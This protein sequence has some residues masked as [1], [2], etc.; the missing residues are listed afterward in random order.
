MNRIPTR[1]R[2]R[3]DRGE[4]IVSLLIGV[5]I[6]MLVL[7]FFIQFWISAQRGGASMD[8]QA[9]AES[10]ALAALNRIGRDITDSSTILYADHDQI[11]VEKRTDDDTTRI[12]YVRTPESELVSQTLD[13]VTG[14][15]VHAP[16]TWAG[17]DETVLAS[18]MR[19]GSSDQV[20]F[21]VDRTGHTIDDDDIPLTGE[22]TRAISRVDM[23]F[24]G[25]AGKG[26]IELVS[27][28]AV[29]ARV[30]SGDPIALP[31]ACPTPVINTDPAE[32]YPTLEWT[33]VG[34][35]RE[36]IVTRIHRNTSTTVATIATVDGKR[37]YTFTDDT[38]PQ[39][40][41]AVTNYQVAAAG[42]GGVS[43]G[44]AFI[45]WVPQLDAPNVDGA[46]LPRVLEGQAWPVSA[47]SPAYDLDWEPVDGATTYDVYSR[48]VDRTTGQPM[49]DGTY[50]RDLTV[51]DTDAT[52]D[53]GYGVQR[54]FQVIAKNDYPQATSKPS[55]G[56]DL[57]THP[58]PTAPVADADTYSVN[59]VT[60]VNDGTADKYLISRRDADNPTS[61]FAPLA[62]AGGGD[63]AYTDALTANPADL[64]DQ[65][66][67][68]T[69]YEYRIEP[70]NNGPRGGNTSEAYT[71]K[72]SVA[73]EALQF[74]QDPAYVA[75][76]TGQSV[77]AAGTT[78][79]DYT[80][81]GR[82]VVSWPT[83]RHASSYKINRLWDDNISALNTTR[84]ASGTTLND[85][86]VARGS[87]YVYNP[88]AQNSTGTSPNAAA[89]RS[90][91]GMKEAY[92][93][94]AAPAVTLVEGADLDTKNSRIGWAGYAPDEANRAAGFAFC[95][96]V[97]CSQ[98]VFR[99]GA[100]VAT[101]APTQTMLWQN[102]AWGETASYQVETCNPGG[103]SE[104]GQ[105]TVNTYP[106]PFSFAPNS[107]VAVSQ[108]RWQ[109]YYHGANG[110]SNEPGSIEVD[111][112]TSVG[113]VHY[114]WSRTAQD[115]DP[116]RWG[117]SVGWTGTTGT[118][119]GALGYTPGYMYRYDV[120]AVA[121]NGLSRSIR[122]DGNNI[123]HPGDGETWV[124]TQPAPPSFAQTGAFCSPGTIA[125]GWK[126]GWQVLLEPSSAGTT[127]P[128]DYIEYGW[129]AGKLPTTAWSDTDTEVA[130]TEMRSRTQDALL[131]L[132]ANDPGS[133]TTGSWTAADQYYGYGTLPANGTLA[134]GLIGGAQNDKLIPNDKRTG[135]GIIFRTVGPTISTHGGRPIHADFGY[136]RS[137]PLNVTIPKLDNVQRAGGACGPAGSGWKFTGTY[138]SA[139]NLDGERR[140]I[141]RFTL[142]GKPAYNKDP[143]VSGWVVP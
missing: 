100:L 81:D 53:E 130:S 117:Q 138:A 131:G 79:G 91:F 66:Q 82:N 102:N 112:Q 78:P 22:A 116:N 67:L 72:R 137:A 33:A 124:V 136:N 39:A 73:D 24:A 60:W 64:S 119:T 10:A 80:N 56:V 45:L 140:T 58:T 9:T 87:H 84:T 92:Q 57:L 98:R 122:D 32:D 83:V 36:F 90:Q 69:R 55:G 47:T 99:N 65:S 71:T 123:N 77:S 128:G 6:G 15:Y 2:L 106:G 38:L 35:A 5:A 44:C 110:S 40:P 11:V 107:T 141:D 18:K 34:G 135:A 42:P 101:P 120:Q 4:G 109:H 25:D 113:A 43:Q 29:E 30:G 41:W 63:S 13:N 37:D 14:G 46:V 51:S 75:A 134:G 61:T 121:A 19:T 108:A 48:L 1:T 16:D 132:A 76:K 104:R 68:S 59:E 62:T 70:V 97:A 28:A 86:G 8:E 52:L 111:W 139:G 114:V 133:W 54:E 31:P 12:R 74:P 21:Y 115:I 94:P 20:F 96:V 126:A 49:G 93:R 95:E 27:S 7:G 125:N 118:S 142:M 89:Y 17:A 88:L 85:T 23:R 105:L 50:A 143:L 26:Y 129:W 103:C 127:T 3:D